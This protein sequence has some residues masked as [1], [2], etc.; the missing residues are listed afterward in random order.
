ML[1]KDVQELEPDWKELP[2]GSVGVNGK[3]TFPPADFSHVRSQHPAAQ[4]SDAEH[5]VLVWFK[6]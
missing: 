4:D 3:L 5:S 2:L 1:K 6:T